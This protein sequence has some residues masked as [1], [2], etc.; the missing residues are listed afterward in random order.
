MLV[1]RADPWQPEYGVGFDADVDEAPPTIDPGVETDDWSAP[2]VPTRV[3]PRG[4]VTFVDGVRRAAA[5]RGR[6]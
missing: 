1:L 5:C 4:V 3:G 2:R 6:F